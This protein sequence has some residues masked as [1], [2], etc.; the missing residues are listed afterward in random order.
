MLCDRRDSYRNESKVCKDSFFFFPSFL[1]A[2]FA[3]FAVQM[4]NGV[5]ES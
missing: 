2:L 1:F 3:S 4:M 5:G